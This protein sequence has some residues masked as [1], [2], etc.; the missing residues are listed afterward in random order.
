MQDSTL[1]CNF[2]DDDHGLGYLGICLHIKSDGKLKAT[3]LGPIT[4]ETTSS[5][6]AEGW[7]MIGFEV[8]FDAPNS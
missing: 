7:N 4:V 1:Y 5:F 8:K 3:F 6:Y 2:D